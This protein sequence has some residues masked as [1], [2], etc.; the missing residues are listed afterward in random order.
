MID[1]AL[2]VVLATDS[3]ILAFPIAFHALGVLTASTQCA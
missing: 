2:A 3:S 1:G